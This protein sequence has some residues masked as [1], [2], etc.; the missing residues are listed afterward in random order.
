MLIEFSCGYCWAPPLALA[1]PPP[2]KPP[3]SV[4]YP[5]P[6]LGQG[7]RSR[8]GAGSEVTLWYHADPTLHKNVYLQD[9]ELVK[10]MSELGRPC[11]YY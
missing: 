3:G 9:L 8:C 10:K 11:T 2:R 5:P 6:E 7:C 4:D 1:P